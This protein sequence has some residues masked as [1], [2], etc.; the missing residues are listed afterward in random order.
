[1]GI[2]FFASIHLAITS[3]LQFPGLTKKIR[4]KWWTFSIYLW[5]KAFFHQNIVFAVALSPNFPP[6]G[7]GKIFPEKIC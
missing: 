1:V 7:K 2:G 5:E 4:R 3:S 6:R